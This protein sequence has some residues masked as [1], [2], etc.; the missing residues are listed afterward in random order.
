MFYKY[1]AVG[2]SLSTIASQQEVLGSNPTLLCLRG[3]SLI[4]DLRPTV[5][6]HAAFRPRPYL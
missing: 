3:F 5:Q 1:W 2:G 6:K 4:F